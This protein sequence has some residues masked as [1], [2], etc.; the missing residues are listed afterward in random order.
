[1][2]V[3]ALGAAL[4]LGV[5]SWTG[6]QVAAGYANRPRDLRDLQ[7]GLAVLQTE[8][9]YGATPLP[10]ALRSASLAAGPRAGPIFYTAAEGMQTGGGVTA[11]EAMRAALIKVGA[12]TSLRPEDLEIMAALGA[13]LGASDRSD[14]VRHLSLARERLVGEE[15]RAQSERERYERVARYA[16]VLSGAA[17]VLILI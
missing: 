11:G 9:E 7:T 2:L 1:V 4:I 16:G 5:T 13:M 17:I 14:Q 15:G 10:T 12:R 3:E 6:L 8:V